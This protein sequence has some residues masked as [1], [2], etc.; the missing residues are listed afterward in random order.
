M[1]RMASGK[2]VH[3]KMQASLFCPPKADD[4]YLQY[5]YFIFKIQQNIFTLLICYLNKY[6]KRLQELA[7]IFQNP[8][9]I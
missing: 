3:Q 9:R 4:K 6:L 7:I 1:H 2:I 8:V 5:E